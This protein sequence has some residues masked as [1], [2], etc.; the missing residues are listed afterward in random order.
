M[1]RTAVILESAR[2]AITVQQGELTAPGPGEAAVQLEACGVCH[3]DLFVA[4]LEKLPLTPLTLGHEGIGRVTAVG[5]NVTE[6]QPGDRVGVTFLTSTCG[7]CELCRAGLDRY[8]ARQKNAGY[9][10]DGVMASAAVVA[11]Q[12]LAKVPEELAAAEAAPLCCAGWTAYGALS[13]ANLTAGQSVAIFG[14]GGLGHL[15][16][17]YAKHSGLRT[18]A[19][20][21]SPEKLEHARAIGADIVVPADTGSR[22]L[23]KEHGGM[24]AALVLT[25]NPAAVEQAFRSVKRTGTVILVG[26]S[27]SQYQLPL[28][29][30]VLKGI[31]I[32]GSYLGSREDLASVFR[33][34]AEGI[35]KPQVETHSIDEAPSLLDALHKG[36]IRGRGV[37][38]F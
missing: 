27:T 17:Q 36:R 26:L 19:A 25:G 22:T 35:V 24:D 30:T 23:Q 18:A 32:R 1:Q 15:A 2:G 21:I 12:H 9:T 11:V 3:S 6:V 37:I 14:M 4:G 33:L 34:A 13:A 31:T 38:V 5:E 20:D 8:C 7:H 10:V 28:V 16:I 29:D